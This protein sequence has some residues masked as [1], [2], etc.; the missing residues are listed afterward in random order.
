MTIAFQEAFVAELRAITG[1]SALVGTRIY[2]L[3]IPSSSALPAIQ[4][5]FSEGFADPFYFGSFDL[6]QYQVQ[7]DVYA[8]DY[9][10]NQQ[11]VDL[12]VAHFN[13]FSGDFNSTEQAQRVIV[14]NVLD[15]IDTSNG[16]VY[17]TIIELTIN[18]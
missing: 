5:R 7:I 18:T 10:V 2:P 9:R 1:L 4:Y 8:D 13:G 11:M 17:R 14:D 15:T 6:V 3:E 16:R 12:I